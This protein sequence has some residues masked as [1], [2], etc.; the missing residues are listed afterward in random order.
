[1]AVVGWLAASP[2]GAEDGATLRM[3]AAAVMIDEAADALDE[4]STA[5]NRLAALARAVQAYEA[6]LAAGREVERSLA[7]EASSVAAEVRAQRAETARLIGVLQTLGRAPPPSLLLHPS[8]PAGSARAAQMVASALPTL[9]EE[10]AT[11]RARLAEVEA[12]ARAQA[13]ATTTLRAG[14]T[15]LQRA[16]AAL[17]DA[18]DRRRRPPR[19]DLRRLAQIRED[20]GDLSEFAA[21]LARLPA[22]AEPPTPFAEAEG[23]LLPPV[24]GPI[25]RRFGATDAAGVARPGVTFE[26]ASGGLVVAPWRSTLRYAGS[27]LDLGQIAMLEPAPDVLIVLTGLARI[28]REVGEIIGRGEPLGILGGPTGQAEEFMIESQ[29]TS[30]EDHVRTLYMELRRAGDPVDPEPWLQ[31]PDDRI[32]AQ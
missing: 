9:E 7:V 32:D 27:F 11:L 13:D 19:P 3:S 10:A 1:M 12:V 16:R 6:G 20:S 30:A 4:A 31:A 15:G 23:E 24:A 29:G 14:L 5:A 2:V 22:V 26:A 17:A 25:L 8:G 21:L 18:L 28:D